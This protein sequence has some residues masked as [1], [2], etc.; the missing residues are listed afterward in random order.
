LAGGCPAASYFLLLR[1]KKVAKEKATP[2]IPKPR[3][4]SLP[5]GRQRTRPAFVMLINFCEQGS[6]TFAADPPGKL[7]FRRG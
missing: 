4:S 6:N 2:L 5:G 3:K 7:D 1:Q